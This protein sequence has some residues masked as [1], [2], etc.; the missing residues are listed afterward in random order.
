MG[1]VERFV[2][3]DYSTNH[4]GKVRARPG[5]NPTPTVPSTYRTLAGSQANMAGE[6]ATVP[7]THF[8]A[9]WRAREA[10]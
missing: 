7:F 5:V 3:Y 2:D 6:C 8:T 1:G 4:K 9:T 10:I